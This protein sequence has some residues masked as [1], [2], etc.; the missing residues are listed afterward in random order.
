MATG[1]LLAVVALLLGA[2]V[3]A[4]YEAPL[5]V[6]PRLYPASGLVSIRFNGFLQRTNLGVF[7]AWDKDCHHPILV[8]IPQ[9]LSNQSGDELSKLDEG[10]S[11]YDRHIA[12]GVYTGLL[13]R[14]DRGRNREPYF[15][16]Q[17]MEITRTAATSDFFPDPSKC[18]LME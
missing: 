7:V 18:D 8:S 2:G 16:M 4:F 14:S 6:L 11:L 1:L 10:S 15:E 12:Q 9:S 5:S 3:F 13:K 17:R